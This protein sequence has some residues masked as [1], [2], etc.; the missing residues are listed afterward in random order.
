MC[1]PRAYSIM[2]ADANGNLAV[3]TWGVTVAANPA[4]AGNYKITAAPLT[5]GTEGSHSLF[6][7]ILLPQHP[8]HVAVDQAFTV[9][10]NYATCDCTQI[11]WQ[12]PTSK[13]TK[14]VALTAPASTDTLVITSATVIAS[15]RLTTPAI[16][17]C[18]AVGQVACTETS[19]LTP[20]KKG[21]AA[22][23]K[24]I[25]FNSSTN[26]LNLAPIDYNDI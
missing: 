10:V 26:T 21:A 5:D 20:V 12:T 2:E 1:G 8:T 13:D 6:L 23:P 14:T 9:V 17:R 4:S 7:R 15:S 25:T 3:V 19:T 18:Y 11:L 16:R 24:F 22:L